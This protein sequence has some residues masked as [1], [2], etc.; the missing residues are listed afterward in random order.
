ME[1][2][3]TDAIVQR[4]WEWREAHPQATF[5]EIDEEVSRQLAGLQAQM[6]ESLSRPGRERPGSGAAPAV[7]DGPP[8]CPQCQTAMQRRGPRRRRVPTRQ[9]QQVVLQRPYSVCP[10][11][12]AG[13]F[14]PG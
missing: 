1:N 3:S 5:D 9:G 8:A 14:P 13:R 12:G 7:G 4:L 10:V 11:C 2:P 6:V